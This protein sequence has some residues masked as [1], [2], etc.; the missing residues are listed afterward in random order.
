MDCGVAG[1][2]S[3]IAT[4]GTSQAREL[5]SDLR[6]LLEEHLRMPP[7]DDTACTE[8]QLLA[9]ARAHFGNAPHRPPLKIP[10]QEWRE[11]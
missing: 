11:P 1:N 3:A 6:H 4:T 2:G 5:Q 7:I 8:K 9:L 10:G